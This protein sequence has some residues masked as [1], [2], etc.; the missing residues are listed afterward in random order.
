[1]LALGDRGDPARGRRPGGRW[2]DRVPVAR[3]TGSGREPGRRRSKDLAVHPQ[4]G[5]VHRR[6]PRSDSAWS[7]SRSTTCAPG[8]TRSPRGWPTRP[9]GRSATPAGA[10]FW[11]E[12]LGA[13]GRPG[14]PLP[15]RGVAVSRDAGRPLPALPRG[16]RP[17]RH[18]RPAG[19]RAGA[20]AAA[21]RRRSSAGRATRPTLWRVG[22][23]AST[24][25]SRRSGRSISCCSGSGSGPTRWSGTQR[26]VPRA[27][28][29]RA[30][31]RVDRGFEDRLG[32]LAAVFERLDASGGD[33][34]RR[35]WSGVAADRERVEAAARRGRGAA[36]RSRSTTARTRSS[37]PGRPR[38]SRRSSSGSAARGLMSEDLP[39]ARAYH[40]PGVRPGDRP[41]PRLLRRRSTLEP[42]AIPLYSCCAAGRMPDDAGR[43]PPPGRRP[44][45]PARS[46]SARRSRRCTPTA[47]ASSSTSAP[48]ATWPGSSRTPCAAG[49]PSPSPRTCRG[50]RA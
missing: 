18:G 33:R 44:V 38:R 19:P 37:W 45:D 16:P 32:E 50:G 6:R 9:A 48:G 2:L 10:Y 5:R 30:S 14:V 29:G 49:P 28:G 46:R 8:S 47:S 17:V 36:S 11:D 20:I 15:G 31:I 4:H 41:D 22:H 21:E 12:P 35:G 3:S 24:S 43:D 40:T 39:F 26:R 23:G 34:P 7:S 42:P 13:S 1:M 25:C 27:G